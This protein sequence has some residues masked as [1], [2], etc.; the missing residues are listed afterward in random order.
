MKNFRVKR[1]LIKE[2]AGS[3]NLRDPTFTQEI[4]DL[5]LLNFLE[6][7]RKDC[8]L[9]DLIKKETKISLIPWEFSFST[10][11]D[12]IKK[13]FIIKTC[14]INIG[15][16]FRNI[17]PIFLQMFVDTTQIIQLEEA[18]A[19]FGY[20]KQMLAN[21][22]HEFRTPLNAMS[23]SL[24][25]MKS[26]NQEEFNKFHRICSS[27]T[28]ILK[29]LVEDIL[30]HSKIETGIFEI[31]EEVFKFKELFDEIYEIFELQTKSKDLKLLFVMDP[32]LI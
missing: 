23:L 32:I 15:D 10:S 8:Q 16:N 3:D 6:E 21:V 29:G 12:I 19:K 31:Q 14:R 22:S 2:L 11:V 17:K 9:E 5:N 30:D 20:Q 25:L 7:E 27:S 18:K 24:L 1:N 28:T 26:Q 4:E 13:E